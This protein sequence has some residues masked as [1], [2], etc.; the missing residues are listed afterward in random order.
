MSVTRRQDRYRNFAALRAAERPGVDF[1]IRER[2]TPS[3]VAIIAP[4][5]GNIEFGTSE[6]A[7]A[8]AGDDYSFY[9]F[10]GLK[11]ADNRSLHITSTAFD[12]PSGVEIVAASDYVIAIH[13][14]GNM[15]RRVYMGGLDEHLKERIASMIEAAGIKTES[16]GHMHL[17][18]M[19]PNN[20]CNRGKRH[21]GAQL[22]ISSTLRRELTGAS[23]R[24][25]TCSAF[26]SAVRGAIANVAGI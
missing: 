20:I 17:Q 24:T 26:V 1:R 9:C 10:E 13:G 11:P 25:T 14:W 2:R 8:I 23:A 5:G 16:S 19:N 12:E 3:R 22:E 18:A 4:H 7:I 6:L 15:E 21:K